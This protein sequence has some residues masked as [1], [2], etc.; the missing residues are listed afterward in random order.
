MNTRITFIIII[1]W[2]ALCGTTKMAA[3]Q[4]WEWIV[5]PQYSEI[6]DKA[7]K[8]GL[9]VAWLND[10]TPGYID[11]STGQWHKLPYIKNATYTSIGNGLFH[12]RKD[13]YNTFF[14]Q[15]KASYH[16]IMDKN[17][18]WIIKPE[19]PTLIVYTDN[20]FEVSVLVN[21]DTKEYK[22][23]LIDRTG[24]RVV[25][26][27]NISPIYSSPRSSPFNDGVFAA[28]KVTTGKKLYGFMDE[29]GK[30]VIEPQF[31][32][33]QLPNPIKWDVNNNPT[34]VFSEGLCPLIQN[35]KLGFIDKTGK[36][37][38]E[39]LFFIGT[40]G[41]SKFYLGERGGYFSEG[42]AAVLDGKSNTLGSWGYIDRTGKWVIEPKFI[43]AT[44]FVNGIAIV[45]ETGDEY[46]KYINTSGKEIA[47]GK[48]FAGVKMDR[49]ATRLYPFFGGVGTI[50]CPS[51]LSTD[52]V[53]N[54]YSNVEYRSVCIN[55]DGKIVIP[56][57]SPFDA[58]SDENNIVMLQNGIAK[59]FQN[60]KWGLIRFK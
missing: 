11:I 16:G 32:E 41:N 53:R 22:Y 51:P 7:S 23:A 4:T 52:N 60:G 29:T 15:L 42:L 13:V 8:D 2:I 50:S 12:V 35:G 9:V 20:L 26:D 24:K 25:E 31:E 1:V 58:A 43:E 34:F 18:N 44:P 33:N 59:A 55:N 17:G 40:T 48:T 45:R 38:I 36:F 10:K 14:Y 46:E 37:V 27:E 28:Y 57:D 54:T 3:Q 56:K 30:W 47:N 39:P 49:H 19:Y 5:Q 21:K 6:G